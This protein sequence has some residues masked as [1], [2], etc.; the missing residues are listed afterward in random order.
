MTWL[1]DYKGKLIVISHLIYYIVFKSY[2]GL[3]S[4]ME[5]PRCEL[6]L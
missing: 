1:L 4:E 2:P 3:V 6:L 5:P